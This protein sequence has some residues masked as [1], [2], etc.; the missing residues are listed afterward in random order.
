MS[1]RH[2]NSTSLSQWLI[3]RAACH[4]PPSFAARLEEEWLADLAERPSAALRLRFAI[5]CCWATR[6]IAR[7][8]QPAAVAV[9]GPLME[10]KIWIGYAPGDSGYFPRRTSTLFWVVSL[11]AVVFYILMTT[12]LH[13]PR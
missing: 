8:H 3:H 11:H 5:G 7:E 1:Q 2:L 4:A 10:G 13:I 6:V 9:T 12:V